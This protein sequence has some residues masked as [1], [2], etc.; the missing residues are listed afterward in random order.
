MAWLKLKKEKKQN[1]CKKIRQGFISF[2]GSYFSA[3]AP[4]VQKHIAQCPRCRNRLAALGRVNLA[5]SFIKSQSHNLDLLMRANTQTINVLKHS[6]REVPKAQK[7]KTANPEPKL[8]RKLIWCFQPSMNLAACILVLVLMKV[9]IFSSMDKFQAQ[10]K[11][12]YKQ[13]YINQLGEEIA[14]DV[15]PGDF[16]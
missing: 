11:K 16:T 10:G 5:L 14:D 9:G 6:L 12:A 3:D 15:F 8:T 13:F 7:L 1:Q 4:W 2:L